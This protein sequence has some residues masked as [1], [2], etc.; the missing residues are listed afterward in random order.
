MSIMIP[1]LEASSEASVSDLHISSKQLESLKRK[2]LNAI[3]RRICKLEFVQSKGGLF[4]AE[5][6]F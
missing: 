1:E 2:E 5:A 6:R 4:D 3:K